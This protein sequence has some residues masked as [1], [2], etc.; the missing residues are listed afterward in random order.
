MRIPRKVG[1]KRQWT[2]RPLPNTG[3]TER[4]WKLAVL[5]E[6]KRQMDSEIEVL[7]GYRPETEPDSGSSTVEGSAG[8]VEDPETRDWRKIALALADKEKSAP[9]PVATIQLPSLEKPK[10]CSFSLGSTAS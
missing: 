2:R 3:M 1:S 9:V 4:E 7:Q 6:K 5:L 8:E 10:F